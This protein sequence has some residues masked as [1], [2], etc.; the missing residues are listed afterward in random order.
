MKNLLLIALVLLY[1]L[2]H[3][4]DGVYYTS[5]NQ[6]IPIQETEI[7]VIKEVLTIKRTAEDWL[8]VY[9]DYTFFNPGEEKSLLVGF[10]AAMPFGDAEI[11]PKD[12]HH[13]YM[14]D[15]SVI[16]NGKAL[17]HQVAYVSEEMYY[18][19]G[20]IQQ[21]SEEEI[22]TEM[23]T[24]DF[25]PFFYVYHFT[26][27]FEKGANSLSHHYRFKLS[28]SVSATYSFTYILTAAM[29]WA[30]QQ[31]DDFT[32][33][34]DLG[35]FQDIVMINSFFEQADV[36]QFQGKKRA[37]N[38]RDAYFLGYQDSSYTQFF[39]Q[40]GSLHFQAKNFRPKGEIILGSERKFDFFEQPVFDFSAHKL[41]FAISS[42]EEVHFSK[43][44]LSFKILRN[45]P[46]ARRGY[47]FKT[48]VIQAYYEE[49]PWYEANT[50]YVPKSED[51][52][53]KETIWLGKVKAS[54]VKK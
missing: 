50:A 54:G 5:G 8:D 36:W 20:K 29:R 39:I 53:E 13:P 1:S 42:I 35:D 2:L 12:G 19:A 43:D 26:S 34:I 31:I 45:Y 4:N 9:V 38:H 48:P 33:E 7:S 30:N 25:L 22:D 28:Q 32:L 27:V 37:L 6:L 47:V 46:W 14:E 49:L 52:K 40:S 11:A 21:L 16:M 44:E 3:A 41:P 24:A 23:Y 10:E 18:K 51:L 17:P 15:F